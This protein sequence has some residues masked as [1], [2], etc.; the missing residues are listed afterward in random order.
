PD[1]C[2]YFN[3]PAIGA[4]FTF[5]MDTTSNTVSFTNQSTGFCTA[6]WHF[7]DGDSSSSQTPTHTYADSGTYTVMLI[8]RA[9][10]SSDTIS[11]QI[12][13]AGPV[14]ITA[15]KDKN[16]ISLYPNPAA[17]TLTIHQTQFQPGRQLQLYNLTGQ[18]TLNS[19]LEQPR[20]S[21]NISALP[22]GIYIYSITQGKEPVIRGKLI[23]Q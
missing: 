12:T 13:I 8:V 1:S 7:G 21:I 18:K 14:G 5:T 4:A 11:M 6:M 9:G 10:I 3:N 16:G 15:I 23:V 17:S 20:Q 19:P 2:G 22:P